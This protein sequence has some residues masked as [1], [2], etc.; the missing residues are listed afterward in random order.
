MLV[1]MDVASIDEYLVS[2]ES[3]PGFIRL[4]VFVMLHFAQRQHF[5]DVH[6]CMQVMRGAT[7]WTILKLFV[8]A[9]KISDYMV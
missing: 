2:E 4:T 1:A 6:I 9:M 5:L 8:S 3:R 7:C